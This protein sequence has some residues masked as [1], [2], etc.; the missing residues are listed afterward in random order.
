LIKLI[1]DVNCASTKAIKFIL[2]HLFLF[3]Q[4]ELMA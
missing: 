3:S 1:S 4:T 2:F